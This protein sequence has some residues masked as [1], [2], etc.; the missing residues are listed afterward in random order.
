MSL[1][2]IVKNS[3]V[4]GK[5]PTASQLAN[6]E[7]ALNY[8]ADGPFI[9]CKDTNGVVRRITGVWIGTTAPGTPQP[10]ELWLDTNTNPAVLKVYKDGTDT[11]VAG[12]T[13][14][15]ATTTSAGIVELATNAET[16]TGSD[17]TRAVTPAGLQSKLSDSTSTTSSTTIASSS[18]VKSAYDLANNALPKAGGRITGALEIGP[19]GSLVF[20]GATDDAF[21]L[22]LTTED[23]TADR[24]ITLPNVSGTVI[25]TGDTG[26]VTNTML[27]GSIA[28]TKLS[29]ISTAG[30]VSNS[31]TTA[32]SANTASAIVARDAS[33]NF[34]AGTITANL[35]GNVTGN[36][37]G[38][39]SA[40]ADNTVTSAK[41]VD[42][43][44]VNADINASAA[45]AGTK[46]APNFG[47]QN[48]TTTGTSTAA[49]FIPTSST[50]P[51]NGMYLSAANTLAFNTNSGTGRLFI[52]ASGNVG[53]AQAASST[54]RLAVLASAVNFTDAS[55][56]SSSSGAYGHSFRVGNDFASYFVKDNPGEIRLG[57][58]NTSIG[59]GSIAGNT[60]GG[61]ILSTS[62][63]NSSYSERLRI[64]STGTVN[65]VGAGTAGS[66]QAVS[67]NGSAPIN[68]VVLDSS[69][70]LG[71]GTS[72]PASNLEVRAN[73][74][75]FEIGQS[76]ATNGGT[77]TW[78]NSAGTFDFNTVG[79]SSWPIVF[80]QS[81]IERC[82]L[83]SSGRLLVG[84]SASRT[85]CGQTPQVQLEGLNVNQSTLGLSQNAN[86]ANSPLILFG[87]SRATTLG[88][89]DIVAANDRLG[90]IRFSGGDGVNLTSIAASIETF[91]D[92]TPGASDMPGRLVFSTTADGASI[93]TER[94]RITSTGQ[95]RLAGAGITFNGD[96]ATANELDDYEEGTF[97]PTIVGT[98][99]AGTGTYTTQIGRYTKIGNSVFFTITLAWSAHTGTGNMKVGGLPFT[100]DSTVGNAP[101]TAI[102]SSNLTVPAN[103]YPTSL[104]AQNSTDILLYSIAT[105]GGSPIAALALDTSAS[106]YLAGRYNV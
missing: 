85:V 30:K 45:I 61:L 97:T 99:T 88:G 56:T 41:I 67:F 31:A 72:S 77:I 29:T 20:E 78:N 83:D 59:G 93:P 9:S 39:A 75:V 16:Q 22:T 96:T 63:D 80:K 66:T 10:G 52:D 43:A 35:T 91:V 74:P 86:D 33:G 50:A 2:I 24:T 57:R 104:V 5:E 32:T 26:T 15:A 42:G 65:I 76:G 4:S 89:S 17:T 90:G 70:R 34:T 14:G 55:I 28:D 11:W 82:R 95:V 68:S 53:V 84:T 81:S 21:E 48:V 103:S 38:T 25:T 23:P 62:T 37:T 12:T 60:N 58:S 1:Q 101:P 18:A 6:G 92:G 98:S 7:L 100:S 73:S 36:L 3:S 94:L 102:N 44:I 8:H 40:I 69:G 47:A 79:T 71:V 87:K 19:T 54:S 46:I 27:A 13:V 105:G 64:T 49:S 51:A 106:I